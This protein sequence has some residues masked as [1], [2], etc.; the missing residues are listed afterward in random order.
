M[1]ISEATSLILNADNI[2]AKLGI[3]VLDMGKPVNI[4]DI[5]YEL[6]RLNGLEPE[7]DIFVEYIGVRP[8]EKLFEELRTDE[9]SILST[10]HRKIFMMKLLLS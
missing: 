2:K 8:G 6:V 5:A 7:K 3:F 1:S 4:K 9:E 10:A